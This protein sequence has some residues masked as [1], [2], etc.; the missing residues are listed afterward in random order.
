MMAAHLQQFLPWLS[1]FH[2]PVTF[3]CYAVVVVCFSDFYYAA[4]KT[5]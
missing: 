3:L 1:P 4:R 2:N 5:R